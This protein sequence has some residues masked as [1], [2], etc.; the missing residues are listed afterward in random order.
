[1][2]DFYKMELV[3]VEIINLMMDFHKIA[4]PAIL[5]VKCVFIVAQIALP[6]HNIT[7]SKIFLA[8]LYVD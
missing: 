4:K 2:I 6:V 5:I 3:Y 8:Y 1:M 7:F